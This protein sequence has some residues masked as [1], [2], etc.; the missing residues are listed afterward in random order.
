QVHTKASAPVYRPSLT[1]ARRACRRAATNPCYASILCGP[2]RGPRHLPEMTVGVL[3]ITS[4]PAPKCLLGWLDD[5]GASVPRLL[6]DS[7]DF[8][9]RRHI[10]PER[11]L[12]GTCRTQREPRVVGDAP[13]RPER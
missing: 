1:A 4:V 10:V 7:S 13:A 8:R 11:E 6:H 12:R 5:N 2:L 9:L 3:K